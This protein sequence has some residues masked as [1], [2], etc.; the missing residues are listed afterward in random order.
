MTRYPIPPKAELPNP[1]INEKKEKRK[2]LLREIRKRRAEA[3]KK[4]YKGEKASIG[5]VVWM[6][7]GACFEAIS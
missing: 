5:L 3:L 2:K 4:V 1:A 6:F 7:C